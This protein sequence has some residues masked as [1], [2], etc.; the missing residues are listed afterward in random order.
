VDD[1]WILGANVPLVLKYMI[2]PLENGA[3]LSNTALA[4]SA[5]S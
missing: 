2:N 4:T 5:C 3:D 1:R